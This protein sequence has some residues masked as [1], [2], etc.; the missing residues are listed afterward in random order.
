MVNQPA[1]VGADQQDV[2]GSSHGGDQAMALACIPFQSVDGEHASLAIPCKGIQIGETVL[3]LLA[4]AAHGGH[5]HHHKSVTIDPRNVFLDT[6]LSL[7]AQ[8]KEKHYKQTARS[9]PSTW[10]WFP[11]DNLRVQVSH[12]CSSSYSFCSSSDAAA[13]IPVW[14]LPSRH[15]VEEEKDL[16]LLLDKKKLLV[17]FFYQTC[18]WFHERITR[19]SN[20]NYRDLR[21]NNNSRREKKWRYSWR[22]P[23]KKKINPRIKTDVSLRSHPRAFENQRKIEI[24]EEPASGG[25]GLIEGFWNPRMHEERKKR[26]YYDGVRMILIFVE[27]LDQLF[28]KILIHCRSSCWSWSIVCCRSWRKK[29]WLGFCGCGEFLERFLW[30]VRRY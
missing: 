22:I 14:R 15:V 12:R 7:F 5:H 26:N 9:I 11:R 28:L 4:T 3:R 24:L 30:F 2:V 20:K 10:W 23:E 13:T 21:I 18:C 8:Q 16:L 17:G 19:S 1:F 25:R 6:H 29:L 27:D